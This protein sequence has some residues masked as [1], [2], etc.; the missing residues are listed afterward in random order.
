MEKLEKLI[1]ALGLIIAGLIG[2]RFLFALIGGTLGGQ[3]FRMCWLLIFIV[4]IIYLLCSAADIGRSSGGSV[5]SRIADTID[6]IRNN[7]LFRR[8]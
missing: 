3:L 6:D 2:S 7:E 4:L 5:R 8:R 1:I